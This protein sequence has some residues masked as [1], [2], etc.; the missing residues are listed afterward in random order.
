[1]VIDLL[2]AYGLEPAAPRTLSVGQ[3]FGR[4]TV[5]AFGKK[6]RRE[7][8][9]LCKCECGNLSCCGVQNLKSGHSTSCGCLRRELLVARQREKMTSHGLSRHPLYWTWINMVARCYNKNHAHYPDYGGRGIAVCDE[10]LSIEGFVASAPKGRLAN[11]T[12]DRIDNDGD[13]TPQNC[14]WASRI[15]Q[16]NNKRNNVLIDHNG[17]IKTAAQLARDLDLPRATIYGRIR[18]GMPLY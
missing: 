10:W 15:I 9:A 13:Y 3:K 6:G 18:R 7:I 12:L 4:L 1:M 5:L 16:G 2:C 8:Y 11:L 14:H 17:E